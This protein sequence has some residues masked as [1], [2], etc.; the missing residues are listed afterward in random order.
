MD[1]REG[2]GW[3]VGW[4]ATERDGA[5]GETNGEEGVS[6]ESGDKRSGDPGGAGDAGGGERGDSKPGDMATMPA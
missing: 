6:F 2:G 3:A 5:A 1:V 4:A